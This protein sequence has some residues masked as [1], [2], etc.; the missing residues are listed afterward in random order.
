MCNNLNGPAGGRIEMRE[1]RGNKN[2]MKFF[3]QHLGGSYSDAKESNGGEEHK[4]DGPF[5][6][7]AC[8]SEGVCLGM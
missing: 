4:M 8:L 2:A 3:L 1:S 6:M 7:E 5:W